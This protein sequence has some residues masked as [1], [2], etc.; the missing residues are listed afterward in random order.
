MI[1]YTTVGIGIAAILGVLAFLIADS[2]KERAVIAGIPIALFLARS[3][4]SGRAG[5]LIALVG[6][7][8]YGLGCIVFLRYNGMNIR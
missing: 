7:I 4:I 8:L 2:G 5:D 3:I 6:W 1:P